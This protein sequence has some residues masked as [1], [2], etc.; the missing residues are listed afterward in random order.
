[1]RKIEL[2]RIY[3]HFKG[4]YYYVKEIALS[5]ETLEEYVVYQALYDDNKIYIRKL[6][7]FLENIDQAR[8]DNITNQQFRFELV[9]LSAGNSKSR[10]KKQ[11]IREV[12]KN[13]RY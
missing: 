4:N 12:I 9:D 1:M 10:V 8:E 6:D 13:D 5:S 3:R 7:M 2:N 11:N